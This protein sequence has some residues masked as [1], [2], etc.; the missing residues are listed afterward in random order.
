MQ[1]SLES[2]A[3]ETWQGY[4]KRFPVG[5][6]L[7]QPL[8][9]FQI[10]VFESLVRHIDGSGARHILSA[11]CGLDT[12]AAHLQKRYSNKLELLL[13]DISPEILEINRKLFEYNGIQHAEFVEG[14]V[15]KMPFADRHFDL[16]YNTGLLEHFTH[17]EQ[18]RIGLETFRLLAPG[19]LFVSAN[20]SDRGAIYKYGMKV[21]KQRG[22][23]P[24]GVEIPV[25][26]LAF[27][28]EDANNVELV[29]EVERDFVG[30]MVFLNFV[31]PAAKVAL[32]PVVRLNRLDV[33]RRFL[34]ATLGSL[35]GTYLLISVFR[36]H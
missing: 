4:W 17:D 27:I 26:S 3:T 8:T 6:L 23:W 28:A 30:Q 33:V 25:K 19:G 34:D 15:F 35:F 11:G 10:P 13:L 9:S 2:S 32:W 29:E 1:Q 31:T 22:T 14:S 5:D 7:L 24:Y 36:A 18:H 21:A 20:P 12:I 16:I